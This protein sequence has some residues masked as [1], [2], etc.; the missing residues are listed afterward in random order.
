MAIVEWKK[1]ENIAI[2][3]MNTAE[4]RHNVM[5]A[6]AMLKA[7]DEIEA[8]KEINGIV[9]TSSDAKNFSLGVDIEWLMPRMAEKDFNAIKD[10]MYGMNNVFKRLLLMPMPVVAA[11]NGHAFGNGAIISCACDF[12]FMR[13]DRG[14]FCYPEVD[15][16]IPFLPGMIAFVKKAV[17]YYTFNEMKLTGRRAAALELEQHH[18]I[19]KAC[20]TVDELMTQSIAFAK[21]FK[22]KRG[23]F[24]EHKKR[25]HKHIIE[26]IDKEDPEFIESLFLFIQD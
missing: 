18:V 8:D 15:L 22:K 12:R 23:I 19:E 2:I 6:N 9:L 20:A 4:N 5:F 16:G 13:S 3:T 1:D 24:G 21:S 17:P 10:F 7:F 11:I 14:F 26:V 25:L